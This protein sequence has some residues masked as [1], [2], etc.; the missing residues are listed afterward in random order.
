MNDQRLINHVRE[1]RY[2]AGEMTQKELADRAGVSR[3]SIIAVEQGK[4]RPSV[5][6]ALRL[7]EVFGVAVED[8]FE[9][10]QEGDGS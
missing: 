3:Q 9:L 7:A 4:F 2:Q 1:H 5:E 8:L 10:V 6:L